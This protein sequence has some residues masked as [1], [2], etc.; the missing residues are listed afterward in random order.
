MGFEPTVPCGTR[1]FQARAISQTT[2]PLQ[3]SQAAKIITR[4]VLDFLDGFTLE[5]GR[6]IKI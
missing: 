6:S 4:L 3:L 1:A 5:L 2:R